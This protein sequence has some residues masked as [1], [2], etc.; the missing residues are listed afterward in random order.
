[1]TVAPIRDA[2]DP[3]NP[4]NPSTSVLLQ[5]LLAVLS[6]SQRTPFSRHPDNGNGNGNGCSG[7]QLSSLL[8]MLSFLSVPAVAVGSL[9]IL[10]DPACPHSEPT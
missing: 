1:M 2:K 7:W 8:R 6:D 4:L 3:L 5:L 10:S 9:R